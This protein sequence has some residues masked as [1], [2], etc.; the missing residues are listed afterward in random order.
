MTGV[1]SAVV[2][3]G[4]LIFVHELGHFLLAKAVGIKVLKFSLGFGPKVI[5]RKVGDTEYMLSAVPFGG[6]VRMYGDESMDEIND[7]DRDTA[8]LA[9]SVWR[10]AL[11]VCA[12]SVFNI[13]FATLLFVLIYMAGVPR[14]LPVIGELSKGAPAQKAGLVA[15]DKILEINGNK[16]KYWEE[17]TEIVH[18]SAGK[19]LTFSIETKDGTRSFKI[20][21]ESKKMK[22]LIGDV[23]QLGLIG[24]SPRGDAETVSFSL[25]ESIPIAIKKTFEVIMLTILALVKI[26]QKVLPADTIGGPIMIFQLASKQAST[27]I[28]SFIM[29]LAVININLGVFNLFPIPI[30]DGGHMVYLLIE[31]IRRKPLSEKV[32]I[33]TQK[34]GLALILMLMTFAIY[35]D[36]LRL[37]KGTP[38]P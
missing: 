26:I 2:L 24:I 23:E 31:A 15:G 16:I 17:M 20:T 35:N 11:V 4:V 3:L 38:L 13:L 9:K 18:K 10:R 1:I 22:N 37:F 29:F 14:P 34:V 12:G 19:E 30:L 36:V 6:Y 8:F 32:I 21:P 7:E 28:M 27:G 5:G 25:F 33:I